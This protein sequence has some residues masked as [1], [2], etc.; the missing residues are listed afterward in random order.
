MDERR[1]AVGRDVD[2]AHISEPLGGAHHIANRL[3]PHDGHVECPRAE[4]VDERVRT[5]RQPGAVHR[6]ERRRRGRR[7]GDPPVHRG[8]HITDRNL[9]ARQQQRALVEVP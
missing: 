2:A 6:H 8:D 9:D 3:P 4:V 1:V 5:D 7:L